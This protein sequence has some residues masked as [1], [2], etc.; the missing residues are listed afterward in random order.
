MGPSNDEALEL[1][2]QGQGGVGR[3]PRQIQ[4][5]IDINNLIQVNKFIS[6]PFIKIL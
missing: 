5:G 4:H 2:R 3:N 6:N 1:I